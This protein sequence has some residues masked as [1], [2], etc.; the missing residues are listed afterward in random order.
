MALLEEVERE[1][2]AM[3]VTRYQHATS[4]DESSGTYFYDCSGLLDYALGRARAADLKPIPHT[5]ARP[6]AAEERHHPQALLP[7]EGQARI[8]AAAG[9]H[10]GLFPPLAVGGWLSLL[11]L[12]GECAL[13]VGDTASAQR[14]AGA[15]QRVEEGP[16]RLDPRHRRR[17]VER[18]LRLCH[19]GI[20]SRG[21]ISQRRDPV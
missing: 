14:Q 16:T 17:D 2:H 12:L 20:V 7:S 9:V 11:V 10:S 21:G 5:K 6:L 19:P 8:R 18:S 15:F 13:L 1:L 3:R 4:V